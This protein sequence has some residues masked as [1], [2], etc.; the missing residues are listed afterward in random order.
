MKGITSIPIKPSGL[1]Y[2]RNGCKTCRPHREGWDN[3]Y[4]GCRPCEQRCRIFN[5]LDK[6]GWFYWTQYWDGQPY[7]AV[8]KG[9]TARV[10]SWTGTYWEYDVEF[11]V[12]LSD[13]DNR[14]LLELTRRPV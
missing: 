5:V 9:D 12:R 3:D 11:N 8:I 14:E 4:E 1:P 10:L 7:W 2:P 6:K 13:E